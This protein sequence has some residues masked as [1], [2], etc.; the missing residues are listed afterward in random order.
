MAVDFILVDA[1]K[2]FVFSER[3]AISGD[4]LRALYS[5]A[6]NSVFLLGGSDAALVCGKLVIWLSVS[7]RPGWHLFWVAS[8]LH[9]SH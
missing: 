1:S 6:K 5:A 3:K 7:S 8:S 9:L 4:T 2:I